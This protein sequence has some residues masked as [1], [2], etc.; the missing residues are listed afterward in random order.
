MTDKIEKAPFITQK[1]K[2]IKGPGKFDW[3]MGLI[4]ENI[5]E[6]SLEGGE[7][8]GSSREFFLRLVGF[9]RQ[10]HDNSC[11]FWGYAMPTLLFFA[12]EHVRDLDAPLK[13]ARFLHRRLDEG[14]IQFVAGVYHHQQDSEKGRGWIAPCDREIGKLMTPFLDGDINIL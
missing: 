4:N 3:A 8:Q 2:I 5:L 11:L 1:T 10:G 7:K 6:I 14:D 13:K 9:F 12:V